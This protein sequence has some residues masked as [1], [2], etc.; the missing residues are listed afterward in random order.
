MGS[1]RPTFGQSDSF[2]L[3][4]VLTMT[5]LG[6]CATT[7]LTEGY[8]HQ[9]ALKG[10]HVDH[11]LSCAG[12]PL[13]QAKDDAATILRYYREA[14]MLEESSVVSKGSVSGVHHGCWATVVIEQDHVKDVHYQFAPKSFDAS[15]DCEEIFAN[16][17]P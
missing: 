17:V 16:C 5:I 12:Q 2:P 7:P 6:G 13:R 11:V 10:T 8:P 4:V 9:E 15:N 14:P 3:G 1:V